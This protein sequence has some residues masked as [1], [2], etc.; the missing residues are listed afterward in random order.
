MIVV[1][2][3]QFEPVVTRRVSVLGANMVTEIACDISVWVFLTSAPALEA[4]TAVWFKNLK[5]QPPGCSYNPLT[6]RLQRLLPTPG[7]ET[8]PLQSLG[9]EITRATA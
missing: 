1:S 5:I 2:A 3:R 7:G 4:S 8:R 9:E 6:L